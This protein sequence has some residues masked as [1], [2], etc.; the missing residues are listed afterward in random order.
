M[1]CATCALTVENSLSSTSGVLESK[2]NLS[3]GKVSVTYDP[4]H[5]SLN[6]LTNAITNSGFS[7]KNEKITVRIGGMVC[8][9]C[10]QT[11]TKALLNQDG[12]ISVEVNLS[13]ERAYIQYNSSLIDIWK[14]R[15]IINNTGFKFLGTDTDGIDEEEKQKA[16]ELK[17]QLFKVIS[18]FVISLALMGLMA[19]PFHNMQIIAYIEFVI[20]TPVLI[21]LASPVFKATYGAIRNK[22]LTMD[23]MYAMGIGVAY[24]ASV[25]GTF[26]IILDNDFLFYETTLMLASF[27]ML[28][29]YLEA[30]AKGKTSSAIK[31]LMELKADYATIIQD[32]NEVTIP[33][34]DVQTGDLIRMRPGSRIPVDGIIV[35]GSS[36]VD[37]SMVTG[38][39]LPVHRMED[40]EVIGGTLVTTGT[41]IYRATR[42]GADTMLS[43]IIRL[44]EDAQSSRPPVQ[45]LAD[46]VVTWFIPAVLIIAI[47]SFAYW[48]GIRGMDLRF[49]LQTLIAVLVVA[50][51]CALGLATPTAVTVGIG[52]GAEFG[53]LIRNGSALE[54]ANKISLALFDKTG[55]LTHGKPVVTDIDSFTNNPDFLLSM[56]S[57]L[58]FLSDHPISGAILNAAKERGIE[59][60]EVTGYET[61]SGSGLTGV[62]AGGKVYLGTPDYIRSSNVV[63]KPEEEAVISR[64]EKEGKTT[65]VISRDDTALGLISISDQIKSDATLCIRLL[66]SMG[67]KSGMITGD[68]QVTAKSVA[69]MV[70]I[71]LVYAKVL[72]EGKEKQVAAIQKSG[73]VVAF[74][75]DGINDG[76]ALA[77]ADTG[78]AIGSGTDVAIESA[79]IVLVK[80]SLL[81]F[82]AAIQLARKVMGRIKLNL[83]WAFFYNILLIPLAAGVLYPLFLFRP[84]Y[85]AFAMAFS[86]VTV[87]SLSLLLKKYTPEALLPFRHESYPDGKMETDPV[88]GMMVDTHNAQYWS[89]S[90][91]KKYYFCNKGCKDAFDANPSN[92]IKI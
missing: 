90:G 20:T 47:I 50:C 57:S 36:Y 8:A 67:I 4:S 15:D 37:E 76:P 71:D 33:I 5:I 69:E 16:K 9:S 13:L 28:G 49:S 82:V 83:F 68:N 61:I 46:K 59:P 72:P 1:H 75:G 34:Q 25:L 48:L 65:V 52:K 70:D 41:F 45:K 86:S 23:V 81:H 77:R 54:V 27:L 29:R 56:A 88:C 14:I 64:R 7:V 60:A 73:E 30:K 3:T 78:I 89:L 84:E 58:E 63:F 42:V 55:T 21:W 85:G 44:V 51:P 39:P 91:G 22:S 11:V 43:R 87:V 53:I 92:F 2:V 66:R 38:E 17:I 40:Q 35:S 18:G 24:I 74:V 26:S 80:D 79:D 32:D 31:A 10:V 62:I 6:E 19:L 12:I